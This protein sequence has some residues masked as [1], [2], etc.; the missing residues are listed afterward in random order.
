MSLND[1]NA[2]KLGTTEVYPERSNH[3]TLHT[4]Y[5]C[6]CGK[7]KII[8]ER[9]PGFD[10]FYAFFHCPDCEEKYRFKYSCGHVWELVEK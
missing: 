4:E 10:D 7:G 8:F 1:S 6:A 9:V 5:K 2:I 3:P